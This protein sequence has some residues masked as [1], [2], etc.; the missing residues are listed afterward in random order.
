MI[1]EY[2]LMIN[3]D[4]KKLKDSPVPKLSFF[5]SGLGVNKL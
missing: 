2:I 1:Y 5:T 4:S 3:N